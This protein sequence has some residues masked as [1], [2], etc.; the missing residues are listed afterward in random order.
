MAAPRIKSR[1]ENSARNTVVALAGRVLAILLGYAVRVVFTR[2][3]AQVYVGVN[4]LFLDIINVLS[5]SELGI[6]TAVTYAL[7]KPIAEGDM[8]RQKSIMRYYAKLYRMVAVAVALLGLAVLPFLPSLI[9]DYGAL[10]HV[11]LIYLLYLANA[12][13]SYLLIY[14]RTLIDAHQMS[15]ITSLYHNGFL[16]L[17]YVV[18][19]IVLVV[20]REFV[21]YLVVAIVC[22]V[23]GNLALSRKADKMFP[24]L[25]DRDVQDFDPSNIERDVRAMLL[26]KAGLVVV[27]NTD[28]LVLSSLFGLIVVGIYSNYFLIIGS[29]KQICHEFFMGMAASVGNLGV[30]SSKE[31]IQRILESVLLAAALLYGWA[32]ICLYELIDPFVVLSF[33]EEYLFER[34]IVL[35]LCVNFVVMGLRSPSTIFHDSLGLFY[36]DRFKALS[37]AAV[38]LFA[39]IAFAHLLGP[40]GVFCGTLLATISTSSWIEPWIIYRKSLG[41]SPAPYY[42]RLCAYAVVIAA[43]WALT[44]WVCGYVQG[45]PLPTMLLRIPI[46]MVVPVTVFFIAFW[47][48]SEFQLLV[49]KA[50]Q[51]LRHRLGRRGEEE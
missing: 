35:V 15:F 20:T 17:Q 7:Y 3:L 2:T 22:T 26:H 49:G 39:S 48:T 19:M 36:H 16:V 47:H 13:A 10:D 32:G 38:N 46:C 41:R 51:L 21:P 45:E 34:G 44:A 27:N 23:G 40:I 31:R 24:Y 1:T 30:T 25:R 6:E 8:E 11:T 43:A 9:A 18:Q 4:G 37:E 28:N 5:L 12:V 33:G 29:V 14:K 42:I 50:R